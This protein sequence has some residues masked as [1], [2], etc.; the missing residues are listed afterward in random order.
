MA[1][2]ADLTGRLSG[3][4]GQVRGR[5]VPGQLAS[6]ITWFK[7]GGA[8]ELYFQPADEADLAF[9]LKNLPADIPVLTIGLGSNLL[10]RD[11]G[12][13]GVVIRLS[14]KGFGKTEVLDNQRIRAGAAVPDVVLAKAAAEA[15]IDGLSFYR[16]IPGAVGGA[17]FMNA[18]CYG[19][20]TGDRMIELTG[21]NRGGERITVSNAD[22]AYAYR[23]SG[24]PAG[25]VITS[26]IYEGVAGDRQAILDKMA[27]IT[28]TREDAQPTRSR[29]GGSTFKNPPGHSAWKLIEAAGCRG[30]RVGAA[31]VSQK[32]CNFLI[33]AGKASAHDIETLGETVR[34]RVRAQSGVGLNWEIRRLGRFETGREIGAFLDG[35]THDGAV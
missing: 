26:A 30:L 27:E 35:E 3:W 16:G 15:A 10:I 6:E 7:V 18:G 17:L 11:G 12:I 8:I 2:P 9:F 32:H 22:M 4:I 33:N 23:H 5:L 24:G 25:L 28:R 13:G 14:G 29:T 31:E 21:V 20:E 34:R 19:T 1:V